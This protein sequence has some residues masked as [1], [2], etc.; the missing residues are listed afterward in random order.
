MVSIYGGLDSIAPARL[1]LRGDDSLYVNT[2]YVKLVTLEISAGAKWDI[3][4]NYTGGAGLT[5]LILLKKNRSDADADAVSTG[6]FLAGDSTITSLETT[7]AFLFPDTDLQPSDV[8]DLWWSMTL[9]LPSSLVR[10]PVIHGTVDLR[11]FSA[12][13]A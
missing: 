12:T 11:E 8:G 13:S 3:D 4:T 2:D 5:W 10:I 6:S 1:D 7:I 9:I